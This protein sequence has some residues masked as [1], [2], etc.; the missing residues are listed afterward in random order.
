MHRNDNNRLMNI[1]EV[2]DY[3]AV[4]KSWIYENYKR[5]GLPAFK[6]GQALRFKRAD[7][8]QWLEAQQVAA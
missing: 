4:K 8:D 2:A 5:A 1:D 3:L 7:V 6:I